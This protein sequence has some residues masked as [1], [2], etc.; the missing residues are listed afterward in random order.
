MSIYQTL[1]YANVVFGNSHRTW[2]DPIKSKLLGRQ[3]G[4]RGMRHEAGWGRILGG[5]PMASRQKCDFSKRTV[6]E[7]PAHMTGRGLQTITDSQ[8]LGDN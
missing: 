7:L 1:L 2:I 4:V 3:D 6:H 8:I 5:C